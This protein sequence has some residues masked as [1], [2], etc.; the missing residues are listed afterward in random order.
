M[1]KMTT[2]VVA[3]IFGAAAGTAVTW[4]I[5]KDKY[6]QQTEK[7]TQNMR[8]FYRE[9]VIELSDN[10][11]IEPKKQ[12]EKLV[13]EKKELREYNQIIK[14]HNYTQPEKEG[15]KEK[16]DVPYT[17]SPDEFGEF[18]EYDRVYLIFYEKDRVLV[19]DC[20]EPVEDVEN[21]VGLESLASFGEYEE[22]SVYVRNDCLQ[23]DY[24]ILL[25]KRS[26]KEAVY[27]VN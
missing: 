7:E 15:G 13:F 26:Y 21:T 17:I 18:E 1:G 4:Y 11:N 20:E 9:K 8:E 10:N 14:Q 27:G 5:V 3:F 6:Q 25:D 12:K 22:D 16:M 2:S 19:D 23:C 24:E